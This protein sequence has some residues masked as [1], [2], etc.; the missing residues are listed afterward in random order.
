MGGRAGGGAGLGSGSRG[1]G[2]AAGA[3]ERGLN[4][5]EVKALL[6][7]EGAIR[8]NDYETAIAVDEKGNVVFKKKGDKNSVSIPYNAPIKDAILTHNHPGSAYK[9][10]KGRPL[11]N[12]SFSDKDIITAVS[13]NAKGMR[14][15]SSGGTRFS[16][17]RPKEGWGV[18]GSKIG[19]KVAGVKKSVYNSL[20]KYVQNYKGDKSVAAARADQIYWH[21][22]SKKLS[23]SLGYSYT[24]Q[25]IK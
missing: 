21:L 7:E 22:V 12:Q 6:K 20:S 3:T 15:I 19:A 16:M 17:M 14:I 9:D 5:A 18:K 8:L 1:G 23:K 4:K 10:A 13:M 11:A 24:K 25:K 2:G